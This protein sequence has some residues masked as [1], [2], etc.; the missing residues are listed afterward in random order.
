MKG[1]LSVYPNPANDF[2]AV[3][4]K[5]VHQNDMTIHVFDAKGSDVSSFTIKQGSTIGY[6]DVKRF[7]D[8]IY[9]LRADGEVGLTRKI[10]IQQ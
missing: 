1:E 10:V 3:Q 5:S 6:I 9:Y 8:G 2:I 4:M 7:A